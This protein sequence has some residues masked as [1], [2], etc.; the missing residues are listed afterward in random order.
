[1]MFDDRLR[2]ALHRIGE[3]LHFDAHHTGELVVASGR[4][5]RFRRRA[6][7]AALG[8]LLLG[9]MA[10]GGLKFLEAISELAEP[11]LADGPGGPIIEASPGFPTRSEPACAATQDVLACGLAPPSRRVEDG[12]AHKVTTVAGETFWIVVPDALVPSGAG[13]VAL[14][15]VPVR[16]ESTPATP[17]PGLT[18]ARATEVARAACGD[19]ATCEPHP[20]AREEFAN[21]STFARWQDRSG[22]VPLDL[23]TAGFDLWTL[24]LHGADPESPKQIA[25]DLRWEVDEDLFPRLTSQGSQV[26]VDDDWAGMTL[27][28][29]SSAGEH[30]YHLLQVIPGCQLTMKTPD[31]G[32]SD[33]GPELQPH[34][35][36][37]GGGGTWCIRG[38]YWVQLSFIDQSDVEAFHQS[39]DIVPTLGSE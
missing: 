14:P 12:T 11:D 30:D 24:S 6:A 17:R 27:W 19:S 34:G 23:A 21:G 15:D 2:G 28:I 38:R 37:G 36:D 25:R 8:I 31:L 32:G 39:L 29:P 18:T 5:R 9:G 13:I 26:I 35:E 10:L 33:A 16:A 3:S 20:I 1:M 7:S 22:T 4:R